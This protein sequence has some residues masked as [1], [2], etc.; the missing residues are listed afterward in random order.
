MLFKI[1]ELGDLSALICVQRLLI[2]PCHLFCPAVLP[3]SLRRGAER[4][5]EVSMAVLKGTTD[6]VL[7]AELSPVRDVLPVFA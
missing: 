3:A 7:R 5:C 1:L 4:S 2:C 6:L